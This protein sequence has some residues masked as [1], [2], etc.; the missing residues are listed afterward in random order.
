M[1][2]NL[3]TG[4]IGPSG[5]PKWIITDGLDIGAAPIPV[6]P[7]KPVDCYGRIWVVSPDGSMTKN[8]EGTW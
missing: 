4:G 6:A 7:P 1:I 2:A 5:A 8:I 3:I